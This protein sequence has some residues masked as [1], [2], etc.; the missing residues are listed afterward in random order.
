MQNK[1]NRPKEV[2]V[3]REVSLPDKPP[4]SPTPDL[5]P[6]ERQG[7]APVPGIEPIPSTPD[8]PTSEPQNTP[9]E[10]PSEPPPSTEPSDE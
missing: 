8:S 4:T 2:P 1:K 3:K 6:P 5:P 9:S 7:G 10:P